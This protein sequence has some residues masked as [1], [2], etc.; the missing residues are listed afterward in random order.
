MKKAVQGVVVLGLLGMLCI[1]VSSCSQAERETDTQQTNHSSEDSVL[2]ASAY[3]TE[4]EEQLE[5]TLSTIQGVG[6]CDVMIT[7]RS[8]SIYQYAKR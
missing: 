5:Q 1:L 2:A 6:T 3:C 7:L 8:T 4:L